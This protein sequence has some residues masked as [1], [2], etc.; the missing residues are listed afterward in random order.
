MSSSPAALVAERKRAHPELFCPRCLW[1]TGGGYCP[2]HKPRGIPL[3]DH[4]E[5]EADRTERERW[6]RE[7]RL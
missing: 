6:A 7:D 3:S 4:D 2:R 5:Q 1:Q